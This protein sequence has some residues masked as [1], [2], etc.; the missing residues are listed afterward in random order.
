MDD[1]FAQGTA[2]GLKA[3]MEA[4]GVKTVVN[5]VYPPNTTDFGY[6]KSFG[7]SPSTPNTFTLQ[8]DGT[9]T[10]NN[11]LFGSGYTV[12]ETD[13]PDGTYRLWA[14]ADERGWFREVTRDN[15]RTWADFKL[16]TTPNGLRYA[17]VTKVGPRP[18]A[19]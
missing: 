6:T 16:S 8:D 18:R 14:E 7:T 10:F 1:P 9:A 17:L 5:E 4:A 12:E 11:V 2:Y 3:K 15:N 13:L 19:A